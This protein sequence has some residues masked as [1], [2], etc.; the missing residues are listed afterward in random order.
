[1]IKDSDFLNIDVESE[2]RQSFENVVTSSVSTF[3]ELVRLSGLSPSADFRHANLD[4][5]DFTSADLRGFDFTGSSLRNTVWKNTQWDTTTVFDDADLDGSNFT[6]SEGLEF[7]F[8]IP[9]E[10][11]RKHWPEVVMWMDTL[12]PGS[13]ES[14][15]HVEKL[16]MTFLTSPDSFIR[17][18]ALQSLARFSTFSEIRGLIKGAVFDRNE[19][20]LINTVFSL[21]DS[22]VGQNRGEVIKFVTPML[23]GPYCADAASFLAR[24]LDNQRSRR[25]LTEFMSRQE[26][27]VV[28]LRYIAACGRREGTVQNL[29]VREGW[30]SDPFDF[31][32]I[33]EPRD[34]ARVARLIA[35]AANE[36]QKQP[37]GSRNFA[38]FLEF[39][40]EE[41][42]LRVLKFLAAFGDN[43]FNWTVP[44]RQE[45]VD[46]QKRRR[47]ALQSRDSTW[48]LYE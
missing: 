24:H 26:S 33:I 6:P 2:F 28:R 4:E 38:E 9:P 32:A 3:S 34:V 17:R 12:R 1:M 43:G 27:R 15:V 25:M 35:K 10:I 39:S 8:E 41:I 47:I 5:V 40:L 31:D 14:V 19:K 46:Y 7:A 44:R 23:S 21:L 37:R 13:D 16:L 45:M 48:W 36:E 11:Q 29:M 42:E 22:Y 18:N 30:G 20:S